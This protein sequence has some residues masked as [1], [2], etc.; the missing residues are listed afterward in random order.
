MSKHDPARGSWKAELL[1][2][3]AFALAL[4]GFRSEL[5]SVE[6]TAEHEREA[7]ERKTDLTPQDYLALTSPMGCAEWVAMRGA[8]EKWRVKP[9]CADLTEKSK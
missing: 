2:L 6:V 5:E 1:A 4:L 9:A 3:A 8:G 7:Y